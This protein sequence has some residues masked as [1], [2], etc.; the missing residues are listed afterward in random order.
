MLSR[1]HAWRTQRADRKADPPPTTCGPGFSLV[2]KGEE[3][4]AKMH[5]A[6]ADAGL[7]GC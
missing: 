6:V 2:M 7:R 1:D 5:R 4:F 3:S